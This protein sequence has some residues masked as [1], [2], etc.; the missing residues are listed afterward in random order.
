[1]HSNFSDP[2]FS[3]RLVRLPTGVSLL[4][5]QL[6]MGL[7]WFLAYWKWRALYSLRVRPTSIV[8]SH[9]LGFQRKPE[10][11]EKCHVNVAECSAFFDLRAFHTSARHARLTSRQG[12]E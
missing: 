8:A 2:A 5:P 11:H 1:M 10:L 6:T 9:G 7:D 12:G 3:S 4:F